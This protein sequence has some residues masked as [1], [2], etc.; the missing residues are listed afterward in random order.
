MTAEVTAALDRLKRGLTT[1]QRVDVNEGARGLL[2]ARAPLG[3]QW[4]ALATA[5]VRNGEI[6]LA[7]EAMDRF[8]EAAAGSAPARFARAVMLA[9]TGRLDR[10]AAEIAALPAD[11]PHAASN[12]FLR[13]SLALNRGF[14]AEARP[15]LER[16]VAKR[17]GAGQAWLAL[18]EIADF[19]A[20]PGLAE[21]LE[22]AWAQPAGTPADRAAL[23][24][25]L[26]RARHQRKNHAGAFAAFAEGAGLA[27]AQAGGRVSAWRAPAQTALAFPPSLIAEVNARIDEDHRRVIFVTGLPRSGSTLV[28]QILTRHPA[29]SGGGEELGL[30]RILA[31]EVGGTDAPAL[32][33]W[34]DAGN[35]PN[36][37]VR[38]YLHL[39]SER[40]GPDGRFVDK[41]LEAGSYLG[42]LLALFPRA[43][44]FWCRREPIDN[45]WSAFRT[46]FARGV[47]WSL[48][49]AE[50]GRRVAADAQALDHWTKAAPRRFMTVD[51][52]DLVADPEP[53]IRAISA[54]A[55]L[56]FDAAMLRPEEGGADVTTASTAQ[57]RRPI[58]AAGIGAAEPYRPWLG[59]MIESHATAS[60][61]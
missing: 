49:L 45:G 43:P 46:Y 19:R 10:A 51:N 22:H 11:V 57:V 53:M 27:R 4:Q 38:L 35:D 16:A 5:L 23:G 13:G 25:A 61:Q 54:G 18:T 34:L 21:R 58:N 26:G 8:V 17:P 48:D 14:P 31:Q 59:P 44:I 28:Q 1:Q 9:Q 29:V 12:A 50:T 47:E 33:R 2:A 20:E 60:G 36:S 42:L 39:A 37:L 55:D 41:T 7:L 3:P 40:L 56:D 6:T 30:F 15:F 24:Y 32:R 52:A